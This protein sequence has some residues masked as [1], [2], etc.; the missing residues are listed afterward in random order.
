MQLVRNRL[1]TMAL[2]AC[3]LVALAFG[4]ATALAAG[5]W[6]PTGNTNTLTVY[7]TNSEEFK[8]DIAEADVVLSY[9][10]VADAVAND[11]DEAFTYNLTEEFADSGLVIP[12]DPSGSDWQDFADAAAGFVSLPGDK[13]KAVE[14]AESVDID[15]LED[16]LWLVL[17]HGASVTDD[18]KAYSKYFEYAFQPTVVALPGKDVVAPDSEPWN[19]RGQAGKPTTDYGAWKTAIT[20]KMKTERKPLYGSLEIVKNI[21]KFEGKPATFEF[22]ITGKTLDGKDYEN[23]AS[24]YYTGGTSESVV[25]PHIPAG[26][27]VT[28]TETYTGARFKLVSA[29]DVTAK[30]VSDMAV[31]LG[32]DMASVSFTN[33]PNGN[34][35]EGHGI[36][37]EFIAS[38]NGDWTW[39]STPAQGGD[40]AAA[41]EPGQE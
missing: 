24:V 16:G 2:A 25:V 33:E 13:T 11:A 35:T 7:P 4:G 26:T 39:H 15:G 6:W 19:E 36:N 22:H 10:K 29:K 18:Y 1:G 38:E 27:D 32:G 21:E 37:N 23:Y 12:T 30:I 20:I 40:E 9:Y 41:D 17:A 31:E 34:N 8:S 14:G 5:N 28:V 3:L